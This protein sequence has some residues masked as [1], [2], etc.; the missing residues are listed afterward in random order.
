MVVENRD[1][2]A[3]KNCTGDSGEH[4]TSSR[5]M[6]R[7]LPREDGRPCGATHSCSVSVKT[8]GVLPV[9]LPIMMAV[10]GT[11][12]SSSEF[13]SPSIAVLVPPPSR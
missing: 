5:A 7:L 1:H 4:L 6:L 12:F 10:A 8:R 13:G 11:G 3:D 9:V 2:H